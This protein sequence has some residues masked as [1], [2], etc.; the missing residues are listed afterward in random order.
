MLNQ[1]TLQNLRKM[2]LLGMADAFEQQMNQSLAELSFAE[3]LGLLVDMEMTYRDNKRLARLLS[4]AHLKQQACLED[5]DWKASRGLDKS[6]IVSLA[7]GDWIRAGH[8]LAI[9]GP[10]GSGKSYLACMFGHQACRQ[11]LSVQYCRAPRLFEDL[12]IAHLDG[13]IARRRNQLAKADLLII[14]DW[15]IDQL[16]RAE[17]QDLLEIV[18][19]R[20]SQRSILLAAQLPMELW[21]SYINDATIADAVL[22]RLLHNAHKIM[23]KGES[24]RKVKSL[25]KSSTKNSDSI[26]GN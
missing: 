21:H 17:R 13:S 3:R 9:V 1:Q 6:Q 8:N 24:M 18:E 5:I 20:H 25:L 12:R 15:G 2:K 4:Q 23:L 22:D 7:S 14:D 19:D 26:V 11:G 10:T 16:G